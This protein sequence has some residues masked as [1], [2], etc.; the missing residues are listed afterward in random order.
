M[1]VCWGASNLSMPFALVGEAYSQP[2]TFF[3]GTSPYRF[4]LV[5]GSLPLGLE[6]SADGLVS[7][8]PTEV[9]TYT[10]TVQVVDGSGPLVGLD[11]TLQ[12]ANISPWITATPAHLAVAERS[13]ARF[14]AAAYGAPIPTAQWEVSTD[15]GATWSAIRGAAS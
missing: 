10:F 3:G 5:T 14:S 1:I 13:E 11:Y 4:N 8:T 7:D 15:A 12:V 9:G 6:L 2:L